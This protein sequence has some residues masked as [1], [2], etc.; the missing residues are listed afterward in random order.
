MCEDKTFNQPYKLY[1]STQN[2]NCSAFAPPPPSIFFFNAGP[3]FCNHFTL[4]LLQQHV[5]KKKKKIL[6]ILPKVQV[7]GH[8]YTHMNTTSVA[9]N[10]VTL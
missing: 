4:V 5:K 3:Y 6:V 10:K 7:A 8:N 9:W 2:K 1:L